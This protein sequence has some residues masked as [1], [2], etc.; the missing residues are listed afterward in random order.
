MLYSLKHT[1]LEYSGKAQQVLEISEKEKNRDVPLRTIFT[2]F[3]AD[4][5][6]PDEMA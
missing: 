5:M 3:G 2:N 4:T 1:E 6:R